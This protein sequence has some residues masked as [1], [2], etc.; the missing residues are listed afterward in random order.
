MKAFKKVIVIGFDGLEPK[1]VESMLAAGE[2]PNLAKLQDRGGYSRIR[3][4]FPAQT[5]VAWSSFATGTNPAGHGIFDFLI[6]NPKTYLPDV[7]FNRYEPRTPF[8]PPKLVNR[9]GGT[10]IWQLL[11]DAGIPSIILRCPCT[12]PPD[13]I[14]G[15]MLAGMGVPDIRGSMGTSTFYT[16]NEITTPQESENLI[17]V[18]CEKDGCIRTY[19]VGPRNL[20]NKTDCK[21][22]IILKLN[23]SAKRVI[24]KSKGHPKALEIREGTWSDWLQVKFKVGP[25]Q[26]IR[27]IV[28]F[29][30]IR[31]EPI[32]ELY[33]SPINY[34]PASLSLYPISSPPEYS[35]DLS[36]AIG[37]YYTTGM[38]EDHNGLNNER[39][40]EEAFLQQCDLVISERERMMF[41]ELEKF[42]HGLFFCLFDTPD[43]VQHMF[44]RF[45]EKAHP[46]NRGELNPKFKDVIEENY[47]LC[48][49]IVGRTLPYVDDQTLFIILSDHGFSSFQRGVHLNT[50]LWDHGFLTLKDGNKPGAD[51]GNFF[52]QVDW[53]RTKAYA[54]GLSGIYLNLKNRE[55]HGVVEPDEA[56]FVKESI[57]KTLSG[58]KDEE[59]GKIAVRSVVMREEIYQGT[60]LSE[61]PD[62]IVNYNP[63]YRVSWATGLGGVPAGY[64]E[65]N[66][67]KWSGDHI[68]APELVP[69][70]LFMNQPF[71]SDYTLN[72][73]PGLVDMAPTILA[74]FGLQKTPTMEGKS[75]LQDTIT[76]TMKTPDYRERN[77]HKSPPEDLSDEE[78]KLILDRLKGLGYL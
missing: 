58:L 1:I 21:F 53:S 41:H 43:R 4:T 36:K 62:L 26:T 30:L 73:K 76:S 15:K 9:R 24:L 22:E 63:G 16:S 61:A 34:D 14:Q 37:T 75:I 7:V 25:L 60:Y 13:Q 47:R 46:A 52:S 68:I 77:N 72:E 3:T 38:V 48:D 69:G 49:T 28:R 57:A 65:D 39:L 23:L 8:L 17:K 10:A 33:A 64:F 78:E 67:R 40:D 12:Y 55:A 2:L 51:N 66:T 20:K 74:A 32:F 31:M 35:K 29:Y 50:W 54:L 27:G 70:V 5:P 44:W 19:L 56:R 59:R 71:H 18:Q 45:R 42:E 6:R 11:S